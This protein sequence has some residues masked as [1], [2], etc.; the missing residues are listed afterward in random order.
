MRKRNRANEQKNHGGVTRRRFLG[1]S[2]AAGLAAGAA[3]GPWSGTGMGETAGAAATGPEAATLLVEASR[4]VNAFDP[5]Q[6]LG[7]SMDI[8][9]PELVK[10]MYTPEMVAQCLSTG[11]GPIT[12]RNHTE[13]A[14]QAWHWNPQGVWSEGARQEGYFVGSSELGEPIHDS[15]GYDLPRRGSTR[16]GGTS[17]GYSRLTDGDAETFWKSNPYLT[18]PYTGEDDAL[19][20]QWVV[21][22][23]ESV[24]GVNAVQIAWCEPSARAYAVQY[25]TGDDPMRWEGQYSPGGG[26]V[27]AQ[28]SGRWNLFPNGAVTDGN[29]GTVLLK[30]APA[31]V[32]TRWLRI[33]MTQSN[34]R[35][36]A[37]AADDRREAMGYAIHEIGVGTIEE[38]GSFLD[39]ATHT[40]DQ[41]QTPTYCSST[42][43]WHRATDINP[44]ADQ[45]GMDLF[46]TSGITN[47]LPAVIPVA[48]LFSTPED[49][50]AEIAYLQKR[51]YDVSGVEMG[52]ECDGQYCMPEDYAAL[53]LQFAAAIHRAA[54]GV[55]LGGPVFQGIN[56]DIS[57][58]PDGSGRTS[59]FGRFLKYLQAHGGMAELAFVSFEHYPFDPCTV[60]WADLFREPELTRS[61]LDALRRDGLPADIPL[62]NTESN[63]S[64]EL[65]EYM[66]DIFAGLWLADSVG[67]FFLAGGAAYFHSPIQPEPVRE[68]CHGWATWGNFIAGHDL[69]VRGYTAQYFVGRMINQEWAQHRAGVHQLHAVQGTVRDAAGNALLTSYA[70][71]RPDGDWAL[72]LVNKDPDRAHT[73]RVAFDAAGRTARF[74]GPVRQVTFGKDQY[75][76]HAQ[77][78]QSFAAPDGPPVAGEASGG[79]AEFTLPKASVTVLRG[80][81]G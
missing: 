33:V 12:Y 54:P 68:A 29:G 62:M 46:F 20:P 4:A 74:N 17:D 65:S 40:P 37:G 1:E 57:V 5:D 58:W 41:N 73:V 7:S 35:P 71:R 67:A 53:Y 78:P 70:L 55:R 13:L 69:A 63:L 81:V 60:G 18:Q 56:Q 34:R 24:Q 28:A 26:G 64:W 15:F 49:A 77:G 80:R 22:D 59:W 76:W 32:G 3:L 75:Q 16:N 6:A 50:A 43:P 19:H 2:L 39:L 79:D 9:S 47:R 25:W 36:R 23:L 44:H 51:R 42:D 66:A 10:K 27:G 48:V 45:T 31:P 38:D 30:L 21:V 14:I 8:L 61:C 72:L 52:E 11:W